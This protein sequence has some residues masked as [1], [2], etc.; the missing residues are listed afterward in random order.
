MTSKNK[1]DDNIRVDPEF[2]KML[3]EESVERIR[4][5]ID[6]KLKS[7]RRMTKGILRWEGLPELRKALR[8]RRMEDE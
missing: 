1:T 5:G 2:K 4:S 8:T 6:K 3:E 7:T